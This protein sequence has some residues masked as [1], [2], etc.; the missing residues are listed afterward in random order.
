MADEPR[1][2]DAIDGLVVARL[3]TEAGNHRRAGS[4]TRDAAGGQQLDID[5][6]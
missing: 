2:P 1:K 5:D 3:V 4:R 6:A